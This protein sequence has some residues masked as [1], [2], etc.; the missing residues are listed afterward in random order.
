MHHS[1]EECVC[2]RGDTCSSY[3]RECGSHVDGRTEKERF[4]GFLEKKDLRWTSQGPARERRMECLTDIPQAKGPK[5]TTGESGCREAAMQCHGNNKKYP[6]CWPSS[7]CWTLTLALSSTLLSRENVATKREV[8][9]DSTEMDRKSTIDTMK[10]ANTSSPTPRGENPT[11]SQA[12]EVSHRQHLQWV[13]ATRTHVPQRSPESLPNAS[14]NLAQLVTASKHS[15]RK[16]WW[17][18]AKSRM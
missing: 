11:T 18:P 13:S 12:R 7:A 3:L 9:C 6:K 5:L 16:L 10:E 15:H 8:Q 2:Q 17:L 4:L 1:G 14:S